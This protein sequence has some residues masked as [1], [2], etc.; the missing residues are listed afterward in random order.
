MTSR[1][2]LVLLLSQHFVGLASLGAQDLRRDFAYTFPA[3]GS[4]SVV[5][6]AALR[7]RTE[8][9]FSRYASAYGLGRADRMEPFAQGR[10]EGGYSFTKFQ[11]YFRDVPVIGAQ[12]VVT[13]RNGLV[14]FA[15]GRVADGLAIETTPVV[16]RQ[17]ALEKALVRVATELNL[18]NEELQLRREPDVR[19]VI[20]RAIL[21]GRSS[22]YRLGYRCAI[23]TSRP[24]ASYIIDVDA[25]SGEVLNV[26]PQDRSA[27][28]PVQA[29]GESLYYGT[30]SVSAQQDDQINQ[31]RLQ[32]TD[33]V[34]LDAQAPAGSDTTDP[35]W[36]GAAVDYLAPSC[37]FDT[38]QLRRGLS[39]H[40]AVERSR[41]YFLKVHTRHGWNGEGAVSLTYVDAPWNVSCQRACWRPELEAIAVG[42]PP[43][44]KK[45]ASSVDVIA[46]EYTHGVSISSVL[47][48][49]F[50]YPLGE[51]ASLDESF[52]DMFATAVEFATAN[53]D[54]DWT[55]GEDLAMP[56][57]PPFIRSLAEPKA[58]E[59]PNAY[60]GE[61]WADPLSMGS[62]HTNTG[63]QNF[64]FYLLSEGGKGTI[65]DCTPNTPA[66]DSYSVKG[67][68]IAAA[69]RIAYGSLTTKLSPD[70]DYQMA[71]EG[72]IQTAIQICGQGSQMH[73]STESAWHAVNVGP[74]PTPLESAPA[75]STPIDPWMARL[76]WEKGIGETAW[77]VQI[78]TAADF[79][80]N[81]MQKTVAD[82]INENGT[83]FGFADFQLEPNSEYY[84]RVRR[85]PADSSADCWRP[86]V[87]LVTGD[88]AVEALSPR[89]P[90]HHPWKLLFKWST[91]PGASSYGIQVFGK[92]GCVDKVSG[93]ILELDSIKGQPLYDPEAGVTRR[94]VR[95]GVKVQ[96]KQS[97]RVRPILD[98]GKEKWGSWSACQAFETTMPGVAL[99]EPAHQKLV[100]PW[101]L[102]LEWTKVYGAFKYTVYLAQGR[103]GFVPDAEVK[104]FPILGDAN[105]AP[106]NKMTINLVPQLTSKEERHWWR[107]EVEGP[108]PFHQQGTPSES[109]YVI[110]DGSATTPYTQDFIDCQNCS[111]CS[112]E[113]PIKYLEYGQDVSLS[114]THVKLAEKYKVSI[115]PFKAPAQ[116]GDYWVDINNP[117]HVE[118]IKRKENPKEPNR[119][120]E[121]F[122]GSVVS[123]PEMA[124]QTYGYWYTVQAIGPEGLESPVAH[125][126][127]PGSPLIPSSGKNQG[128]SLYYIKAPYV[129]ASTAQ[130]L[131]DGT[132]KYY[133]EG[134]PGDAFVVVAVNQ[135]PEWSPTGQWEYRI[136]DDQGCGGDTFNFN[137]GTTGTVG[138]G[139]G[140]EGSFRVRTRGEYGLFHDQGPGWSP[141]TNVEIVSM[142]KQ[143]KKD[144]GDNKVDSWEDCDDG[145][146]ASG[147]G[148]SSSCEEEGP[149]PAAC[150]QL[151]QDGDRAGSEEGGTFFV[152][153][154]PDPGEYALLWDT[155]VI[156]DR[157]ELFHG[158]TKLHDTDC[159]G[160]QDPGCVGD[161][162]GGLLLFSWDG[163]APTTVKVVV[164]PHCDPSTLGTTQWA[165]VVTCPSG[166]S[167]PTPDPD[168]E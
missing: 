81:V 15:L 132:G 61:F 102:T 118:T 140:D 121:E 126:T 133:A 35:D 79:A 93:P 66:C 135:A 64:W 103:E 36:S 105:L 155:V 18:R 33:A 10:S 39:A 71:R 154:G 87:G 111:T 5:R 152:E 72:S 156:P 1:R 73:L 50:I 151:I 144:C 4:P 65:D 53:T 119:Q 34:T 92:A 166:S 2:L 16:S 76:K 62:A 149:P 91:T 25:R 162:C 37:T 60:G 3:T 74:A 168:P 55:I 19:L 21:L 136:Y 110:N 17:Q 112:K 26:L 56:D 89:G 122:A 141:C 164:H 96:Q 123:S 120:S 94:G 160:T 128:D 31:C 165:F 114:W 58:R 70:S 22:P 90:R 24:G 142:A 27:W 44:G 161:G 20:T 106:N 46:H 138:W 88:K 101:N 143:K 139:P 117:V 68:G 42:N 45:H 97:W 146:T 48:D 100:Y 108:E 130:M 78:S 153:L 54:P 137:S 11:Q 59:H 82:V 150:N 40:W 159:V 84:W 29:S 9:F 41:E 8:D 148:C 51:S 131:Q 63:V 99:V 49:G 13:H 23:S 147:D 157:L 12:V 115:F 32:S 145:N 83:L 30:V 75:A 57:T 107:V 163:S 14:A 158:T 129:K 28:G 80:A 69:A 95:L 77:D 47:P 86:M 134:E 67:R 98:Y 116:G 167:A 113:C 38:I 52:S 127:K 104:A 7:V 125:Q 124:S 6:M 109:W 85:A 43:P